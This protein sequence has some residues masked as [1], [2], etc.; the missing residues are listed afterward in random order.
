MSQSFIPDSIYWWIVEVSDGTISV[1]ADTTFSFRMP[2]LLAVEDN[3]LLPEQFMLHQNYPNPF[4]PTT[5]IEFDLPHQTKVSLKISDIMGREVRAVVDDVLSLGYYKVI[6]EGRD[7]RGKQ[8]PSGVYIA[9]LVTTNYT[10]S[11]KM[12]LLK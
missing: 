3:G 6:W 7:Q 5:Q 8:V 9:R 10:K 12:V 11:I 4:N 1:Q 2:S